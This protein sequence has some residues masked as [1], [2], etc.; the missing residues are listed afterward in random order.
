MSV[1]TTNQSNNISFN[2]ILTAQYISFIFLNLIAFSLPLHTHINSVFIIALC[3]SLFFHKKPKKRLQNLFDNQ[4]FYLFIGLYLIQII[5]LTYTN[6]FQDAFYKLE[7]KLSIL[8]CPFVIGLMPKLNNKQIYVIITSFAFSCL[9][10]TFYYFFKTTDDF[11]FSNSNTFPASTEFLK[12]ISPGIGSVYMGMYNIF[13]IFSILYILLREWKYTPLG[14]KVLSLISISILYAFVVL[15]EART[16]LYISF[17][18]V[19]I[20]ISYNIYIR[21]NY[22]ATTI[23]L[24]VASLVLTGFFAYNNDMHNKVTSKLDIKLENTRDLRMVQWGCAAKILLNNNHTLFFGIG[25]GD[26]QNN[27]GPCYASHGY[28]QFKDSFNA[29]N[30]YI[31]E[32]LRHGLIGLFI[33]LSALLIPFYLSIYQRR[34]YL[35]FLFLLIFIIWSFTEST[36]S[37]QKGTVFYA[38]FN[39]LLFFNFIDKRKAK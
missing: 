10:I 11:F 23:S 6:D 19:I 16:A 35:Y 36:L 4:L 39:A 1:A 5:G 8:I 26:V 27:I 37:T 12:S 33:F 24:S 30:E 21:K 31:E 22:D 34:S 15:L 38:F 2:K 3:I 25:T 14:L 32:A 29:H 20:Y 17:L 13:A 28:G 18:F 9:L 7:T